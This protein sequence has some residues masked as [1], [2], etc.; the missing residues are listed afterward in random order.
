M[1][2]GVTSDIL[3]SVKADTRDAKRKLRDLAGEEKKLAKEFIES[4]ERRNARIDKQ[5]ALLG[6]LALGV[7]AAAGAFATLSAAAEA[8]GKRQ[9]LVAASAGID[10]GKVQAAARGLISETEALTLAAASQNTAWEVSQAQLETA[11]KAMIS[12]RNQGNDLEEV[13]RRVTQAIVEGNVEALRPMGIVLRGTTGEVETFRK[14]MEALEAE[15]RKTSAGVDLAGDSA[16]RARVT[17]R[18]FWDGIV[19]GAGAA[20]DATVSWAAQTIDLIGETASALV[21]AQDVFE[22]VGLSD[23]AADRASAAASLRFQRRIDARRGARAAREERFRGFQAA[24]AANPLDLVAV[25]ERFGKEWVKAGEEIAKRSED[26]QARGRGRPIKA[27]I[28]TVEQ[29]MRVDTLLAVKASLPSIDAPGGGGAIER[30]GGQVSEPGSFQ[31]FLEGARSDADRLV[32]SFDRMPASLEAAS[33]A[34]NA[35]AAVSQQAFEAWISGNEAASMSFR[36]FIA[37]VLRGLASQMFAKSLFFAAEALAKLIPGPTFDPGGAA[38]AGKTAAAYAAGA[39]VVGALGRQF[40]AGGGGT[41][42]GGRA[43]LPAA[44]VGAGGGTAPQ[45]SSQTFIVNSNPFDDNPREAR[46]RLSRAFDR[47][48]EERGGTGTAI[49]RG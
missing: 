37:G 20:A 38:V 9:Q 12:L 49:I 7:G 10:I 6:K 43:G 45:T 18:D 22:L 8:Y 29:Q 25:A 17:F 19:D 35:F 47:A 24:A 28:L 33:T 23:A 4:Q 36:D 31:R 42:S 34:F 11:A 5:I 14:V 16:A 21:D 13:Q 2:L 30:L 48:R 46:R 44:A 26:R 32:D 1:A 41:Q 40:G 15:A 27:S 39:T 3:L